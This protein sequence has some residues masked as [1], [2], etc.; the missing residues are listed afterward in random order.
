MTNHQELDIT[1]GDYFRRV[2]FE[3]EPLLTKIFT[4]EYSKDNQGSKIKD[5]LV[6]LF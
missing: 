1:S 3:I 6:Y 5:P 2:N 4:E